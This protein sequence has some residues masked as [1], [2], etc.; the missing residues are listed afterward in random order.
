ME[1]FCNIQSYDDIDD[2]SESVTRY[3]ELMQLGAGK[4]QADL[5]SFHHCK[6]DYLKKTVNDR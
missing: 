2:F 3:L 6:K 4:F 5:I 1:P